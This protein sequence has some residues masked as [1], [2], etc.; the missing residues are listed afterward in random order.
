MVG[1]KYAEGFIT[2]KMTGFSNFDAFIKENT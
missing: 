2:E 1:V